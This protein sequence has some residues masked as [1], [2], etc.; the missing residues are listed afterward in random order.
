[1]EEPWS[2]LERTKLTIRSVSSIPFQDSAK[3][4]IVFQVA[5]ES[6][7]LVDGLEGSGRREGGASREGKGREGGA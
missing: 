7:E 4:R 5:G 6:L 2:E 1:M 3:S